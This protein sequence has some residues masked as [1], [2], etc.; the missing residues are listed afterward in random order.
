MAAF[1]A[2]L[3]ATHVS[4]ESAGASTVGT[5]PRL[6]QGRPATAKGRSST[7][8][9]GPRGEDDGVIGRLCRS[10][11]LQRQRGVRRLERAAAARGS[12]VGLRPFDASRPSR[13]RADRGRHGVWTPINCWRPAAAG[14][15]ASG[16]LIT[17]QKIGADLLFVLLPAGAH[18]TLV[19]AFRREVKNQDCTPSSQRACR[20]GM[21]EWGL[22]SQAVSP[23]PGWVA[24]GAA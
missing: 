22:V 9:Q 17:K 6:C 24:G 21:W 20:C 16:T 12:Q 11:A 23:H 5:G 13:G 1:L 2:S 10:A 4:R 18:N 3:S 8:D 15:G 7:H 14:E 19:Y